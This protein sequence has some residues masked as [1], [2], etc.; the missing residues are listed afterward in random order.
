MT[1][2]TILCVTRG[3]DYAIPFLHGME[4]LAE[5]IGAEVFIV[6]DG[7]EAFDRLE[8]F[9][10]VG[11]VC[12][13][14][15][16]ESVLDEAV[17]R[18]PDGYILRLDDD[19]QPDAAMVGFLKARAYQCADHWAFPRMNLYPTEDTFITNLGLWPDLQTRLSV[20]AKS[21]GR[22][23]IHAG[24]PY[25]TGYVGPGAIEHHKFLV[26]SFD[27]RME[28]LQR[29]ERV[30]AYAGSAHYRAFSVPEAVGPIELA[31][32]EALVT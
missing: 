29:Y 14:G 3:D 2:L 10:R 20:K 8:D 7:G 9:E 32:R 13:D 6:A 21:G 11:L 4:A 12:S 27:E 17:S 24:S 18:C 25:G 5:Q 26:R 1:P 23:V 15:Y 31:A 19:E 16:I 28:V 30:A 22:N